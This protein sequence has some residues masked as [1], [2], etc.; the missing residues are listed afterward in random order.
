VVTKRRCGVCNFCVSGSKIRF[1][2]QAGYHLPLHSVPRCKEKDE[3]DIKAYSAFLA[4]L[5]SRA[6]GVESKSVFV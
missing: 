2:L 1:L 3:I 6:A 5:P 4:A